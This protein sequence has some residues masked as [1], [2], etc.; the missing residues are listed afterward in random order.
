[1]EHV[2]DMQTFKDMLFAFCL[3]VVMCDCLLKVE[4]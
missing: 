1:M 2:G 3:L 4:K